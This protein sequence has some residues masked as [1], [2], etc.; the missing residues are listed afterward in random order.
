V[1]S[2]VKYRPANV[3]AQSLVVQDKLT[4]CLREL[5]ALPPALESTGAI[6]LSFRYGSPYSFDRVGGSTKLMRGDVGD[7]RRLSSSIRSM[8]RCSAQISGSGVGMT[9]CRARLGHRDLTARPGASLL[10]RVA[11]SQIRR[12]YRFEEVQH[13]FRAQNRPQG[14]ELVI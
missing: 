10:D 7:Q 2:A 8:A 12:L 3:V 1:P 13:M 5:V 6:T 11:W 9:A 14:E 4:N